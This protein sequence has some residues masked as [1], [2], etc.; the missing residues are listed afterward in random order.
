VSKEEVLSN[1][2]I[3]LDSVLKQ[4][5]IEKHHLAAGCL[6][7][8]GLGRKEEQTVFRAFFDTLLGVNFPV[9]LCGDG[10]ILLCGGL[11]N[12]EGYCLIAGTGSIA[13]GR[14][15]SGELVRAGGHGYMLGDEGSAAWIGRSAI[16]RVLRSLE[17]R[18][19]STNMLLE[20]LKKA[21]LSHSDEL[22]R[23]VHHDA[24]KA[25]IGTLA[26]VVTVAARKGDLLALDILREGAKELTLLVKSVISR[27]PEIK[28][29]SLELAGGV[30]EHDEI[31]TGMLTEN[32]AADFP[33][34]E[35]FS[36]KGS[37]LEGACMLAVGLK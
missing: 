2:T 10:E 15:I 11:D 34:L 36:P 16:S 35:V 22:I 1:L 7:S 30:M 18:D 19:L 26:P 28:R 4:A 6:G 33:D 32:L 37:A 23:Y 3:L 27:S 21:S 24:D 9:K 25:A 31:L 5:G 20:I 13:L 17:K 14:S 29:R 8:A 12:L